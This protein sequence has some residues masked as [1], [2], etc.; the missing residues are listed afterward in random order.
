MSHTPRR[1]CPRTGAP[2]GTPTW[3]STADGDL[4]RPGGATGPS[5][6]RPRRHPDPR[7]PCT[8]VEHP[9]QADPVID[10]IASQLTGEKINAGIVL[11]DSDW[12][13]G[14]S[15]EETLAGLTRIARASSRQYTAGLWT[16]I[17]WINWRT[18]NRPAAWDAL[19]LAL[20]IDP[21]ED[22]AH[23]LAVFMHERVDPRRIRPIH[24]R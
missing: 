3:G 13:A 9:P 2:T 17:A 12:A 20:D 6:S 7:Q 15:L 1:R 22:P 18:N 8:F 23:Y 11:I 5:P 4:R 16:L 19:D 24:W 10:A 14:K 21:D